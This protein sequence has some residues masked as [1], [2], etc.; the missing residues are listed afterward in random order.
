MS[1]RTPLP[2][3]FSQWTESAS[4]GHQGGGTLVLNK[5]GV[6]VRSGLFLTHLLSIFCSCL[7]DYVNLLLSLHALSN[8]ATFHLKLNA[9]PTLSLLWAALYLIKPSP[10]AWLPRFCGLTSTPILISR[11]SF[12]TPRPVG[13]MSLLLAV[14]CLT[15]SLLFPWLHCKTHSGI[16]PSEQPFRD[17]HPHPHSGQQ[18]SPWSR[19]PCTHTSIPTLTTSCPFNSFTFLSLLLE[20]ENFKSLLLKIRGLSSKIRFL[21]DVQKHRKRRMNNQGWTWEEI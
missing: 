10:P 18:A 21:K 19:D 1:K 16:S 15:L 3:L 13:S 5:K 9:C 11:C 6:G 17:P 12:L 14:L 2:L 7:A 20:G 4:T 8:F